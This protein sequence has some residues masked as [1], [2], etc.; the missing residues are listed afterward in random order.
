[1]A[2]KEIVTTEELPTIPEGEPTEVVT[3]LVATDV[4]ALVAELEKAGVTNTEQLQ[5]KLAAS[6]ETGNM[7]NQ[8]GE[9]RRELSELKTLLTPSQPKP[10]ADY[11]SLNEEVDLGAVVRREIKA[12][13]AEQMKAQAEAQK[14][15][16]AVWSEIQSDEDYPLVKEIWEGK[17]QD[18][19]FVFQIQQGQVNPSRAYT[20]IVRGYYKGIA[21]RS[22]DTIKQL[23]GGAIIEPPHVEG[24]E[25]QTITIPGAGDEPK[26]KETLAK[27]GEKLDKGGLLTEQDELA[28][29]E[30]ALTQ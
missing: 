13:R 8:L 26:S 17:L 14:Q 7:A 24:G 22:V 15:V 23:Q 18:P 4:E 5:G 3:E 20:D 21:K 1:M 27:L 19:N 25:T 11:E 29:I 9:T 6:R 16:Q 30:A 10:N 2:D 12:D 28:A